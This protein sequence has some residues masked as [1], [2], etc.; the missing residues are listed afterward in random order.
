M[1]TKSKLMVPNLIYISYH[2]VQPPVDHVYCS[3]S[4]V[5]RDGTPYSIARIMEFLPGEDPTPKE[6]TKTR[7]STK[8]PWTRV[9][10]A[11]Y[12]RPSDV[13][14]RPIN[15]SRL[16]LCAIYSEVIPVTQLRGKCYV[17]HKDKITDLLAWRKRLDCFYYNR[18]FDPFIKREFEVILV[19]EVHNRSCCIS[20]SP[21]FEGILT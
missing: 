8:E 1:E 18:L 5:I 10:V 21:P 20:L 16:L 12:Y 15:D 4:W 13:S 2:L 7:S 3:P 9:R 11:W 6:N 14:D 17:K 19:S